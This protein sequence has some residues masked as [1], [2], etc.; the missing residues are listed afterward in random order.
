MVTGG[1]LNRGRVAILATHGFHQ[2]EL[3]SPWKTLDT[4]GVS[5][6]IVAPARGTIRGW[7]HD[8]WAREVEVHRALGELGPTSADDYDAL[9]VPGGVFHADALRLDARAHVFVRRFFEEDVPVGVI[10][11]GTWILVD[12][13]VLKG[14]RLTSA[15]SMRTDLVN[16]GA[17]WVDKQVSIE[18]NLI[19]SRD[20]L[21]VPAFEDAL[22][23]ELESP[24]KRFHPHPPPAG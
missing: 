24:P 16:A 14:R 1:P 17:H 20:L 12:A 21:D 11:H 5:V 23:G 22:L 9:I 15:R 19:S 4:F 13:G 10:G 18:G 6:D 3:I 7:A 2:A 8:D